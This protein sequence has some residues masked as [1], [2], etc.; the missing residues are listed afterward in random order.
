MGYRFRSGFVACAKTELDHS[1]NRM[2]REEK[3]VKP[4]RTDQAIDSVLD[5]LWLLI[6]AK[7]VLRVDS[8]SFIHAIATRALSVLTLIDSP[9]YVTVKERA[10]RALSRTDDSS[11]GIGWISLRKVSCWPAAKTQS[12]EGG[13]TR[14]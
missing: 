9:R 5:L 11:S 12:A 14:R 4:R 1:V 7:H 3:A 6:A 13:L 8:M 2:P 10:S